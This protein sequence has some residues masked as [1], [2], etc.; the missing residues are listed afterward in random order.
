MGCR[1]LPRP[2]LRRRASTPTAILVLCLALPGPPIAAAGSSDPNPCQYFYRSLS[3]TPHEELAL[4]FGH[5][6]SVLDHQERRGCEVTFRSTGEI[7]A[8]HEAPSFAADE[9]SDIYRR[10]WRQDAGLHAD[11]A[12]ATIFRIEGPAASCDV[13]RGQSAGADDPPGDA[14]GSDDVAITVQC[15]PR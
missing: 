13:F 14:A 11:S 9:G 7:L 6:T 10:G 4:R 12:G 2:P 3:A 5:Y 8:G 1:V 15:S